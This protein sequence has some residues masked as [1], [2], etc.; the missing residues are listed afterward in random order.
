[1]SGRLST[2]PSSSPEGNHV[3]R[4]LPPAAESGQ[5][6]ARRR[7]CR[8]NPPAA[9]AAVMPSLQ[10][11]RHRSARL[12]SALF[13]RYA[14]PTSA[15]TRQQTPNKPRETHVM[16]EEDTAGNVFPRPAPEAGANVQYVLSS[17]GEGVS[18]PQVAAACRQRKGLAA[19]QHDRA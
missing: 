6:G 5:R 15:A 13:D 14:T 10:L 4:E 19:R 16:N 7:R 9:A 18:T 3:W 1:L 17:W 11:P 12:R 2:A 8:A